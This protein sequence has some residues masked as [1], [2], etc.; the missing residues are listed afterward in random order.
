MRLRIGV[1]NDGVVVRNDGV[2]VRNDAWREVPK[3]ALLAVLL[4]GNLT[5]RN[6]FI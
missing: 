3:I 2:V 4:V 6:H 1:R 5:R